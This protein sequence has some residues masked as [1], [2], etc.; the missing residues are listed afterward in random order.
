[1][2]NIF[3]NQKLYWLISAMFSMSLILLIMSYSQ[4][5]WNGKFT[6][7]AYDTFEQVAS[8]SKLFYYKL[9]SGS[10][11]YYSFKAGL[12]MNTSL[13]FAFYA[14]SP[15]N[16]IYSFF[17]A[18]NINTASIII[19]ILKIGVASALFQLYCKYNLNSKGVTSVFAAL[20]YSLMS[21]TVYTNRMNALY[22]AVIF[23]PLAFIA[24]KYS[25]EKCKFMFLAILYFIIFVSNFYNGYVV[26]LSSFLY[27]IF[28]V[29][30]NKEYK[31]K[32]KLIMLYFISVL[33]AILLASFIIF[34]TAYNALQNNAIETA[35]AFGAVPFNVQ[36]SYL[37]PFH[38]PETYIVSPHY[39][40][41]IPI[42]FL[43]PAFYFNNVI[44]KK[45]KYVSSIILILSFL[46]L[47][48][49]PLYLLAHM[50]NDPTGYSCRFVYT[51][52]FLLISM[53]I[54]TLKNYKSID[55]KK[56]IIIDTVFLA[57][58]ILTPLINDILK[59]TKYEFNIVFY[60]LAILFALL[61]FIVCFKIIKEISTSDV[62]QKNTTIIV[63][64]LIIIEL[65][66]HSFFMLNKMAY[67]DEENFAN[68]MNNAKQLVTEVN[69]PEEMG[70]R[71]HYN[72]SLN[73]N[74]GALYGYMGSTIFSSSMNSNLRLF[75]EKMGILCSD[76]CITDYGDNDV[77]RLLL[78]EKYILNNNDSPI[79]NNNDIAG[80][81]FM[82]PNKIL[83]YEDMANVFETQNH[84]YSI[85][86]DS[87][88]NPYT[89]YS[90]QVD[91]E[92]DNT[93]II[94]SENGISISKLDSSS[95]GYVILKIPYVEGKEAYVWLNA[96]S[97]IIPYES[98][99]IFSSDEEIN[100]QYTNSIVSAP[101]IVKM[102]KDNDS[103]CV[104]IYFANNSINSITL[105]ELYFSYYDDS[106]IENLA[107]DLSSESLKIENF[108]DGYITGTI[109]NSRD[110]ILFMSIPYET[111]W[112]AYVDGE[113]TEIIPIL[114]NAFIGIPVCE[115]NHNIELAYTAPLSDIGITLSCVGIILLAVLFII[116]FKFTSQK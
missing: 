7:I 81:G 2:N 114:D 62:I 29:F 3:K 48:F 74:Q 25:V 82:V 57:L 99:Y 94:S 87:N 8:F 89:I 107:N 9:F 52:S 6:Y 46:A 91:F 35:S 21:Y 17:N 98:P 58:Y 90:G 22:D 20:C 110:G 41:G 16:I 73:R 115:G 104:Y 43:C 34:P 101:H 24:I 30:T 33:T 86:N 38:G 68:Y 76:V 12:G 66:L 92:T 15:F 50:F 5:L 105:E 97:N 55:Y 49:K 37:F 100:C 11:M 42:I 102:S 95:D 78:N 36:L 88:I 13:L 28:I 4:V 113:E 45:Y 72:S 112:T 60:I 63:F 14:L 111:G 83:D 71:I 10:N 70:Y 64:I 54:M 79:I 77:L 53:F 96:G 32:L 51:I 26:G 75:M 84:L 39:Y 44:P 31:N 69:S 23:L 65:G 67:Y 116:D 109:E 93:Q 1:M 108:K 103:Y 61:W 47:T 18:E 80:F 19:F 40:C 59:Y 106:Y 27:F 56:V 85:L